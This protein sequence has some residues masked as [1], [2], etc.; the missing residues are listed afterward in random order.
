MF[1]LLNLSKITLNSSS[2]HLLSM[3]VHFTYE[4][5]KHLVSHILDSILKDLK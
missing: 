2:Y 5:V 3:A 1:S 4:K